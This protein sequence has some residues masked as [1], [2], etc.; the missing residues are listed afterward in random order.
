MLAS[1]LLAAALGYGLLYTGDFHDGEVPTDASLHD[2]LL[3]EADD[4]DADGRLMPAMVALSRV[5]DIVLDEPG[6]ATGWRVSVLG[7][8]DGALLVRGPRLRE[9][10]VLRART[11][12]CT[13]CA[14]GRPANGLALDIDLNETRWRLSS[15]CQAAG[16][17]ATETAGAPS[18]LACHITLGH[19]RQQQV[20]PEAGGYMVD[21]EAVLGEDGSPQLLFAGDLDGDGRLDLIL[22]LS[23]HYNKS[24]PTLLL[25]SE[26][27]D[28]ELVGA[29][30]AFESVGC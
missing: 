7:R 9:G 23:D 30:A 18:K 29:A 2:W 8:E 21:G 26:A 13:D 11:T 27:A 19:G 22:D 3:L 15:Q 20:L 16:T 12:P 28:G 10:R 6:Q 25:S 17:P 1:T 5:P 24:L 4:P 14:G